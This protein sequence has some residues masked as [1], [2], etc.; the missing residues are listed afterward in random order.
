MAAGK[1]TEDVS[2]YHN[3]ELIFGNIDNIHVMRSSIHALTD[4]LGNTLHPYTPLKTIIAT[5]NSEIGVGAGGSPA[6]SIYAKLEESGWWKHI[7]LLLCS[8]LF[9]AEKLHLE[10]ASVLVH[11]SDGW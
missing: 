5:S 3:A 11:C 10:H 9:V 1:G 8:S 6:L 2:A 7:R 4:N